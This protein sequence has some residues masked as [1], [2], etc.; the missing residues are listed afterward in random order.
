MS[1]ILL[2]VRRCRSRGLSNYF[3]FFPKLVSLENAERRKL[4]K[5][6]FLSQ[7]VFDRRIKAPGSSN[8]PFF[9]RDTLSCHRW[10]FRISRCDEWDK[11]VEIRKD[12]IHKSESF[13]NLLRSIRVQPT[14][15]RAPIPE[16]RGTN[17]EV[18]RFVFSPRVMFVTVLT[19]RRCALTRR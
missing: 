3:W 12:S 10:T 17:Y 2:S 19:V 8:P 6:A 7:A 13:K 9:A 4:A 18:E 1:R 14:Q 15:K 16:S 11:S 5:G